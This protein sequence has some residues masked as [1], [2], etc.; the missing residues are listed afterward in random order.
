MKIFKS[1]NAKNLRK[2][3]TEESQCEIENKIRRITWNLQENKGKTK[4]GK[5]EQLSI[6]E[7]VMDRY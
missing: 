2:E 6:A 3:Q 5:E 4:T 1:R 7:T